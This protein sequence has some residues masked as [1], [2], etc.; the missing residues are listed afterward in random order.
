MKPE[1]TITSV[2]KIERKDEPPKYIVE[3]SNG[4]CRSFLTETKAIKEYITN[5]GEPER[6]TYSNGMTTAYIWE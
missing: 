1:K 5:A 3:Y 6:H 2:R 4:L